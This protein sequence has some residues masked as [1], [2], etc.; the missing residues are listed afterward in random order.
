MDPKDNVFGNSRLKKIKKG[1]LVRWHT[2]VKVNP[3]ILP[4][5]ARDRRSDTEPIYKENIGIVTNVVVEH[6]GGRNVALAKVIPLSEPYS[7]GT[8][9]EVF[10]ACLKVIS[11]SA[12]T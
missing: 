8:E 4:G 7:V 11:K 3:P 10:L 9:I 6:R 1:D 5:R 12:V 2:L